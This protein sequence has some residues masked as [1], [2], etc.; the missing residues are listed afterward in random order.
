MGKEVRGMKG[1]G[2]FEHN[3]IHLHTSTPSPCILHP[4]SSW[5]IHCDLEVTKLKRTYLAGN[6]AANG[7]ATPI[8][9]GDRLTSVPDPAC[10][11]PANSLDSRRFAIEVGPVENLI[12]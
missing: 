6:A 3:Y 7:H 2:T 10:P 4:G 5:R 1:P 8:S 11:V 12:L 9:A